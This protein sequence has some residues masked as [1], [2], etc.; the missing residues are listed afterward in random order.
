M[1]EFFLKLIGDLIARFFKN[2][3][4]KVEEGSGA[5]ALEERLKSKIK[6]DGRKK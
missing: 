6:K 5:G 3:G 1:K 4:P 2:V